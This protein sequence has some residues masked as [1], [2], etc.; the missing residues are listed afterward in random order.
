MH[1][2]HFT[3]TRPRDAPVPA[4]GTVAAALHAAAHLHRGPEHIRVHGSRA[5]ARGVMF[6]IAPCPDTARALCLTVCAQAIART[7]ELTGW[8]VDV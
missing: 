3:M 5:G 4:D 8:F 6:V 2:V 1:V 7:P